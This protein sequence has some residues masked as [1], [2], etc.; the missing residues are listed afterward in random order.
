MIFQSW[1]L[2]VMKTI[3]RIYNGYSSK[4]GIP[5]QSGLVN[6]KSKIIF[7]KPFRSIDA[8]KGL[9]GFDYLWLLWLS[10]DSDNLTVRP[11]RL[12]GNTRL[13]VFATRSPKRP[14]GISMSSVRLEKIVMGEEDSPYLIVSGA[15]LLNGTEIIDIKP[16][17]AYTDSHPDAKSGFTQN[18]VKEPLKVHFPDGINI[19]SSVRSEIEELLKLDPRPGFHHDNSRIYVLTYMGYEV[20]FRVEENNLFV[21]SISLS[22][23]LK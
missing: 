16:Y 22:N 9:E 18:S 21:L 14:N 17:L 12:G 23:F 6:V 11:P 1:Y 10:E 2:F 13:G 3:A 4:F 19:D 5:R 20:K 7:E 15:D 8:I